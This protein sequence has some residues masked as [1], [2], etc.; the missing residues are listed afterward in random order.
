MIKKNYLDVIAEEVTLANSTGVSVR[1]LIREED[2]A[3]RYA[4]RRFEIN[5]G[6]QIGLHSHAEE[7]EIYV[8]SGKGEIL[9]GPGSKTIVTQGDVLYISPYEE[10]G[11]KNL[12]KDTFVFLC[13]IPLLTK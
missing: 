6:G 12:G 7:H 2:G 1:W 5:P 10:H 3:F 11:Y 13:I 4:M 8:L 9:E